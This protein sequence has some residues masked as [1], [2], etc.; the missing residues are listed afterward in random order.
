VVCHRDHK[1]NIYP[2]KEKPENKIDGVVALCMALARMQVP[3]EKDIEQ[4]FVEL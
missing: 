3:A 1:D 2:N 4:A